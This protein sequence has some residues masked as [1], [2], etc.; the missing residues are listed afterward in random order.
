V[1]GPEYSEQIAASRG[2]PSRSDLRTADTV[3]DPRA[4]PQATAAVPDHLG[5]PVTVRFTKP[6]HAAIVSEKGPAGG[7]RPS[8][9]GPPPLPFAEPGAILHRLHEATARDEVVRLALRGMRLIA[10]RIAVFVVKREGFQGWACNAEFGEE[11][12]LRELMIPADQPSILATATAASLYF[13][14]IPST[15][16]HAALLRVMA[17][18][19]SDVAAIAVRAGSRPAMVLLADQLGDPLMGTR[20]MDE[21]A[22]A[23]GAALSRLLVTKE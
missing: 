5:D 2:P 6:A 9:D 3:R 20:R 1:Q 22:K 14:P 18:P 4:A 10:R 8:D 16:A 23:T 7:A 12:A 15:P 11:A 13:G 19:S 17:H 21:L